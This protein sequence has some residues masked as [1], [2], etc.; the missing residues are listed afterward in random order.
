[1]AS[2][3]ITIL[4][5]TTRNLTDGKHGYHWDSFSRAKT[6]RKNPSICIRSI[7]STFFT[8]DKGETS[9]SNFEK[10]INV[11]KTAHRMLQ[12]CNFNNGS[13]L[14]N[15]TKIQDLKSGIRPEAAPLY[16]YQVNENIA[17]T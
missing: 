4:V 2:L 12:D 15:A 1:M 7:S 10:Y 5:D 17:S 14:H 9:K 11:H 6:H 16:N 3:R 13:G 8:F